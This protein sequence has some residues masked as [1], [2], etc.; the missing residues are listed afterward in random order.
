MLKITMVSLAAASCCSTFANAQ[1]TGTGSYIPPGSYQATAVPPSSTQ[2]GIYDDDSPGTFEGVN[3]W[4]E[5]VIDY[6]SIHSG[7]TSTQNESAE[8]NY[9]QSVDYVLNSANYH[10]VNA[11]GVAGSRLISIPLFWQ[12]ANLTDAANGLYESDWMSIA[13]TILADIPSG[14]SIIYVRTGWEE[15]LAGEMPWSSSGQESLFVTAFQKF[16]QTFRSVDKNN[17]FRFV[18]CPNVDGDSIAASYPGDTSVDVI[19]MGFYY[20]LNND[21][22]SPDPDTAFNEM[23]NPPNGSDGLASLASMASSHKKQLAFGE[24]GVDQDNFGIYVKD[25]YDW[26]RTNSCS[27][28]TYWNNNGAYPGKISDGT[29]PETGAMFRHLFDSANFPVEPIAAPVGVAA[30][31]GVG[32]VQITSNTVTSSTAITTYYLYKGPTSGGESTTPVASSSS[33]LFN[34]AQPNG[35]VA[36]YRMEA[37]NSLSLGYL[38]TEV[39]AT[40]RAAGAPPPSDYLAITSNGYAVSSTKSLEAFARCGVNASG[41][42]TCAGNS[43]YVGLDNATIIALVTPAPGPNLIAGFPNGVSLGLSSDN[44]LVGFSQDQYTNKLTAYSS[45]PVPFP[46]GGMP[47]WVRVDVDARGATT[48]FYVAPVNGATLPA[49]TST[50]WSQLGAPQIGQNHNGI[51]DPN[52]EPFYVAG[53][54]DG[55]NQLVGNVYEA[56]FYALGKLVARPRFDMQ[57]SGTTTFT[58]GPGRVWNI[59]GGAVIH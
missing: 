51:F 54:P 28:A 22:N 9:L 13:N 14:Q 12:G 29:Y 4:L 58:D 36:Y 32:S 56:V 57:T 47:E 38:S 3:T 52:V 8:Q 49:L 24:W 39:S 43:G 37:G 46:A 19:A 48:T 44:R 30:L 35:K 1:T 6:A 11:A 50:S 26:C 17:R 41:A 31:S 15:N 18:W 21:T 7:Q 34:D 40:P 42:S 25:F 33:P 53:Q 16:V 55:S 59:G 2:L 20:G 5:R 23:L 45:A 10:T 27:Y